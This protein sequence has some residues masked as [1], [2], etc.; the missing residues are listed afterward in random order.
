MPDIYFSGKSGEDHYH[1]RLV[2]C[3]LSAPEADIY[4][5]KVPGRSG[6]L[7]LSQYL[8]GTQFGDRTLDMVFQGLLGAD[9][10]RV[11]QDL[12]GN[13]MK[14][15]LPDGLYYMAG[16]C[17]VAGAN[18]YEPVNAIHITAVCDPWRYAEVPVSRS[19]S[20]TTAPQDVT[21]ENRGRMTVVPKLTVSGGN[22]H[23]TVDGADHIL[24]PGAWLLPDLSVSGGGSLVLQVSGEGTLDISYR[25][26]IL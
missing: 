1:M 8:G 11:Q 14:I 3:S 10:S 23:I 4:R 20:V 21:L 2:S 7:D 25:E 12:E 17:H 9:V 16:T 13:L 18:E 24:T 5:V 6:S 15:G 19:V 26:A 22:I